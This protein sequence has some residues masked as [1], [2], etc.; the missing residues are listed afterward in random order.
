MP[1]YAETVAALPEF[2][3]H[4]I[5]G[6]HL[7]QLYPNADPVA[8]SHIR[9]AYKAFPSLENNIHATGIGIRQRGGKYHR[10]EIVLKLFVFD[11]LGS[12]V[13]LTDLREFQGIPVDVENLPIQHIKPL[14]H[15]IAA[16][17]AVLPFAV[18]PFRSRQRPVVGGISVSPL[19]A[20]FVGTLGC[21]VA[22]KDGDSDVLFALSN[23]H[24]F[25]DVDGLPKGTA[26]V[27]PGPEAPS[28]ATDP[29]DVFATLDT[30]IPIHFPAQPN[31][32]VTNHFDAAIALVTNQTIIKR[33]QIFGINYDPTTVAAPTPGMRVMKAG[34]TSGV[35][36]GTISA[37]HVR[38]V[39]VD[40]GTPAAHRIATYDDVVT[41]IGDNG[42]PFS[43]PGDSGSVVVEMDSNHPV[44]LLFAGDGANTTACDLGMLCQQLAVWP[45]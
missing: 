40:Y 42:Q 16:A 24:V 18:P 3:N 44:A 1:T 25:A 20:P 23:N 17:P 36:Q 45:V 31:D 13:D 22:R 38:G 41:I 33:R 11:K 34:R 21:F 10:G 6:K 27:Q 28:F 29:A 7:Q 5:R 37:V 19:N 32:P 30:A 14:G 39:Q 12:E 26:I 9:G 35:T 15:A 4:V 43:V 8:A 2:R